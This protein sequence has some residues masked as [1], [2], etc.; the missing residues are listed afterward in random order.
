[1][2][3]DPK[4]IE[5]D[6]VTLAYQVTG[7]GETP[8]LFV[9]AWFTDLVAQWRQPRLRSFLQRLGTFASVI[10]V[11]KRG[12][13]RSSRVPADAL[14]GIDTKV[15]DLLAVL[16]ALG[17]G[18]V[19][20]LGTSESGPL[21]AALAARHPD[22][23]A[24]LVLHATRAKYGAPAPDYPYGYGEDELAPYVEW[25]ERGW[26]SE[27]FAAEFYAWVAPSV[28]ADRAEIDAFVELMPVAGDAATVAAATRLTYATTD[29]RDA[30]PSIACPTL[31]IGRTGDPVTPV[32]EVR[33]L[34]DHI[35]GATLVVV[36]GDDHPIWA[37]DAATVADR[38]EAFVVGRG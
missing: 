1:M 18:R 13:G 26:G 9:N 31:V 32:E 24:A 25:Y 38:I 35:P 20:V 11:D 7:E 19:A 17:K 22:R 29:V 15:A 28:A 30:L 2:T 36:K 16:D 34:A 12:V 27:A 14:P 33:W 10:S 4:T 21:T 3:A 8:L 6:G 23:V 37:G 5:R